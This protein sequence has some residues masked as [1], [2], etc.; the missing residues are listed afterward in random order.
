MPWYAGNSLP[1]VPPNFDCEWSRK[2]P[3]LEKTL[4]IR[5]LRNKGLGQSTRAITLT[6][7][8]VSGR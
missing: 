8:G 4:L 3:L 2:Q 5:R 6:G 7:P 1:C